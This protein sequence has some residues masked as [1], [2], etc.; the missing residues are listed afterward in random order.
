MKHETLLFMVYLVGIPFLLSPFIEL[1]L[2][3]PL[4]TPDNPVRAPAN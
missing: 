2:T 4:K 1:P 3:L